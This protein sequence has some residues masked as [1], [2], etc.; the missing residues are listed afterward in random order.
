MNIIYIHENKAVPVTDRE[1]LQI[2]Y[3]WGM[4]IIYMHESKAV[5]VTDREGL[6]ICYLLAD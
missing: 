2:C 3:L 1:G 5:P 4:N 6:Q